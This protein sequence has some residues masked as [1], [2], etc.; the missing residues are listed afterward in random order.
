ME[1]KEQLIKQ[2]NERQIDFNEYQNSSQQE[3][4]LLKQKLMSIEEERENLINENNKQNDDINQLKEELIQYEAN[5]NIY[6]E[7]RKEN[8]N[9]FNNLAQAFQIKEEEYSDEI[10]KLKK[11][12]I[13]LQKELEK[14]KEKYE[15]KINLLTLQNNEYIKCLKFVLQE[16]QEE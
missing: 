5:G 16:Q 6:L 3:I 1:E 13:K 12:N 10:E 4:E 9:K 15:K 8:D 14:L 7:E 2:L 11:I